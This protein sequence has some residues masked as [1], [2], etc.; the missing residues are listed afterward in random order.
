MQKRT[1]GVFTFQF[2]VNSK[3]KFA[4]ES[5]GIH[6]QSRKLCICVLFDRN[7]KLSKLF[8]EVNDGTLHY[9]ASRCFFLAWPLPF[10]KS[11]AW[12]VSPAVV[13]ANDFADAKS[14]ARKKPLARRVLYMPKILVT[15]NSRENIL[16]TIYNACLLLIETGTK[17]LLPSALL[18]TS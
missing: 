11:F 13:Y 17:I 1:A 14:Y 9:T 2:A 7:E 4:Y 15:N 6:D 10:A 5:V 18:V 12:L 16:D 3:T 8:K